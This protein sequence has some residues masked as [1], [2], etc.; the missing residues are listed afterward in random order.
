MSVAFA[1]PFRLLVALALIFFAPSILPRLSFFRTRFLGLE[2]TGTV[3]GAGLGLGAGTAIK[4]LFYTGV[5]GCEDR[6]TS[7]RHLDEE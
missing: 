2:G 3:G 5:S 6:L 4:C 7:P 1:F